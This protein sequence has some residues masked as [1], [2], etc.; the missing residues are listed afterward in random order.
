MKLSSAPSR[1]SAG[2]PAPTA[3][4]S[5]VATAGGTFFVQLSAQKSEEDAQSTF[6]AL[7][8]KFSAQLSGRQPVIRRK[9]LEKGVFYGVQVGPFASRE[10]AVQLCE[11]L[12]SAGGACI[13]QKI[14]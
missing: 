9:D 3:T 1:S 8:A 4:A 13:I 7:Q 6:R 2:N 14:D 10:D 5:P 11:S 12:K